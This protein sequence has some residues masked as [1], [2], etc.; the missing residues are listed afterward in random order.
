MS[1]NDSKQQERQERENKD[2]RGEPIVDK[3][4]DGVNYPAT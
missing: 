3:K 1:K 2:R 4:K